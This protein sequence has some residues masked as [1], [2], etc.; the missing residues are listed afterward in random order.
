M[1]ALV[2][3][4]TAALAVI[5]SFVPANSNAVL[6][7]GVEWTSAWE[8]SVIPQLN[9]PA[10]TAF[11][12]TFTSN[13]STTT[14]GALAGATLGS[15]AWDGGGSGTGP[16]STIEFRVRVLSQ[17]TQEGQDFGTALF[18]GWNGARFSVMLNS[19][20]TPYVDFGS[21]GPSG[22]NTFN[23][24]TSDWHVYRLVFNSAGS[25]A[26]SLYIDG[27]LRLNQLGGGGPANVL[28]F[29]RY[30]GDVSATAT[31]EWDYIRWTNSGAFVPVPEP[32]SL[33]LLGF[34][35]LTVG[36]LGWRRRITKN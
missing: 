21:S 23:L 14:A 29:G 25:Q 35:G 28:Q 9:D 5:L 13:G 18:A 8:G 15:P 10:F 27:V 6:I 16:N 12:G 31:S 20:D 36:W 22:S 2:S 30:T 33:A 26:V 19:L 7:D 34:G 32:G 24:N 11:G 17:G 3:S 4:A 1:K